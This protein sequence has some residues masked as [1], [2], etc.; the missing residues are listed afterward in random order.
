MGLGDYVE[1]ME[2][3]SKELVWNYVHVCIPVLLRYC[4]LVRP[5]RVRY[6]RGNTVYI[7]NKNHRILQAG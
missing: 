3:R 6:L 7:P 4:D 2:P 1:Q 5:G